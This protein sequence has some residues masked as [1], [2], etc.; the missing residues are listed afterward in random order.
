MTVGAMVRTLGRA[1][2]QR[3]FYLPLPG[4]GARI[5]EHTA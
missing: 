4:F 2:G 3:R 5:T 1:R